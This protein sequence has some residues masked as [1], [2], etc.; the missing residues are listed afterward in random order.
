MINKDFKDKLEPIGHIGRI[1]FKH[2][3]NETPHAD[4]PPDWQQFFQVMNLRG[5][6]NSPKFSVC[7]VDIVLPTRKKL[8]IN[9]GCMKCVALE[10]N[11]LMVFCERD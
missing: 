10:I 6:H 3:G 11:V 5:P 8:Y 4:S 7:L 2:W 9:S 1:E